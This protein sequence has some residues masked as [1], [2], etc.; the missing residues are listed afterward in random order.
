MGNDV[1]DNVEIMPLD[2]TSSTSILDEIQRDDYLEED[3]MIS[4]LLWNKGEVDEDGIPKKKQMMFPISR[5]IDI[6]NRPRFVSTNQ[7]IDGS[8]VGEI[9]FVATGIEEVDEET[10]FGYFGQKW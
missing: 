9:L 6:M 7:H 1:L 8:A 2:E 4:V 5:Y 10:V 3:K